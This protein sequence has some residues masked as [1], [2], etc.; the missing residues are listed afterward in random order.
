[1]T[2]SDCLQVIF[3]LMKLYISLKFNSFCQYKFV[4]TNFFSHLLQ[5]LNAKTK[6]RVKYLN[7]KTKCWV[8][9]I[10]PIEKCNISRTWFT[11]N[12]DVLYS[13]SPWSTLMNLFIKIN[14]A[15]SAILL[16]LHLRATVVVIF[17]VKC[18]IALFNILTFLSWS[19][20]FQFW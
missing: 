20:S 6:C 19:K 5:Y 13:D 1:M 18:N 14:S 17:G 12:V 16:I 3:S 7:A 8:T 15:K 10:K 11:I 2:I 9:P 4:S